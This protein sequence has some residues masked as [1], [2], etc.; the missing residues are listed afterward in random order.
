VS[1]WTDDAAM[2]A[3]RAPNA[4]KLQWGARIVYGPVNDEDRTTSD[5]GGQERL[6]R[7]TVATIPLAAWPGLTRGQRILSNGVAHSVRDFRLLDDGVL[8]EVYLAA[9]VP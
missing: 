6:E 3:R 9:V 2:L 7:V 8:L 4:A 1:R 5:S